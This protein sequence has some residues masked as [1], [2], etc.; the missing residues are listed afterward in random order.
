[1]ATKGSLPYTERLS[2]RPNLSQLIPIHTLLFYF[3]K[4]L[5]THKFSTSSFPS[6][7]LRYS[8]FPT[9]HSFLDLIILNPT[10]AADLSR[11]NTRAKT[12]GVSCCEF[13][14]IFRI[15]GKW[16]NF[17]IPYRTVGVF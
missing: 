8:V 15:Q 9:H 13:K 7:F 5:S 6:D 2:L 1:M 10:Q 14:I 17:Y 3:V 12:K 4:F 11:C 16:N